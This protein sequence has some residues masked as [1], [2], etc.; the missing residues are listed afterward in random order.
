MVYAVGIVG[1]ILGF[2]LGQFLLAHWLRHR[3]KR[4]LLTNRNL[5][6]R[7]GLF[8]WMVAGLAAYVAIACYRVLVGGG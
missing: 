8:N 5:H 1:F 3:S 6:Y 2:V 7:Y 4:D